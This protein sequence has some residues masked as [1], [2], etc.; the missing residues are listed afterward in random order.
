MSEHE[1]QGNRQAGRVGRTKERGSKRGERAVE[2]SE[3]TGSGPRSSPL[4]SIG[5]TLDPAEMG[6]RSGAARRKKAEERTRA[7]RQVIATTLAE[8]AELL[9]EVTVQMLQQ[10]AQ[11][12]TKAATWVLR[13]FPEG[14]GR[15]GDASE[16][17]PGEEERLPTLEEIRLLRAAL[18][19]ADAADEGAGS[20][21]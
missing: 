4:G 8:N 19:A 1:N 2:A 21:G 9:A 6:R 15:V 12:D 16:E 10:A 3:R 13:A 11:G 17:Q 5:K 18:D 7:P 20:S 14:F